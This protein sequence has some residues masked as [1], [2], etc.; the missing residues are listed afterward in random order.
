MLFDNKK[1]GPF[2]TLQLEFGARPRGFNLI[3]ILIESTNMAA[4][5]QIVLTA[6][7]FLLMF[8]RYPSH[9]S[10][11]FLVLLTSFPFA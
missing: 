6:K 8:R 5:P 10:I 2:L 7:F 9:A 4:V 11:S 3:A 1:T